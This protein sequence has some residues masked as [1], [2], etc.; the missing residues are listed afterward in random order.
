MQL[1]Q[2]VF[3]IENL[4]ILSE[5]NSKKMKIKGVF[6]RC[7]EKNNNG[8]VYPTKVLES[9]LRQISSLIKERRLCGELDHPQNDTV[10]LSNASHLITNLE[11]R[12]DDLIGEAEILDTPAGLTAKALINGGVKIGISSRGMG[13]LS[14]DSDGNKVVN[15]DFRLITFDLVSDPST[16]GAFPGLSESTQYKYAT[17]TKEKL[18]KEQVFLTMLESKFSKKYD[19]N[20]GSLGMA[21]TLR[22]EKAFVNSAISGDK[23]K[24]NKLGKKLDKANAKKEMRRKNKTM[25]RRRTDK[26]V[27]DYEARKDAEHMRFKEAYAPLT[28][29]LLNLLIEEDDDDAEEDTDTNLASLTKKKKKAAPASGEKKEGLFASIARRSAEL[30]HTRDKAIY[31]AK[32]KAKGAVIQAKGEG[33]A[34]LIKSKYAGKAKLKK[35]G[36]DVKNDRTAGIGMAKAKG[37]IEREGLAQ[38]GKTGK[39]ARRLHKYGATTRTGVAASLVKRGLKAVG[40]AAL[41]KFKAHRQAKAQAKAQ[42]A[43]APSVTSKVARNLKAKKSGMNAKAQMM[44]GKKLPAPHPTLTGSRA[45]APVAKKVVKKAP[46][47]NKPNGVPS[48]MKAMPMSKKPAKP[49]VKVKK[50]GK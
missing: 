17:K 19:L 26:S 41:E 14:E 36:Y 21:K 6:G 1:L 12:G 29:M 48:R 32:G 44:S 34:G 40:S 39:A 46:V 16:R 11:F 23:A 25:E 15:E 47:V 8:R 38:K 24:Q 10:K 9:Q 22:R 45:K 4:Q 20:E 13:T 3:I 2:D 43:Q 42:A 31:K 30:T 5:A 7:N 49:I 37:A 27:A 33:K 28:H 35:V 18:S 50:A